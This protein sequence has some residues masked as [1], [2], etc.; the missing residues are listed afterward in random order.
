MTN[1]SL[2]P[3]SFRKD[4]RADLAG[5]KPV[6]PTAYWRPALPLAVVLGLAACTVPNVSPG[7]DAAKTLLSTTDTD[8]RPKLAPVA[9][10]ELARAEQDYVAQGKAIVELLGTCRYEDARTNGM[11]LPDCH[12]VQS[13]LPDHGPVNATEVLEA[14]DVLSNYFTALAAIAS[15]DSSDAVATQT[16]AVID[17]LSKLGSGSGSSG[18]AKIAAF[19]A[20]NKDQAVTSV[21]F[22]AAQY[23]VAALRRVVR[24]A[25]P[26]IDALVQGA[27]LYLDARP[28]GL[29]AAEQNMT[30][31]E[32]AMTTA[33]VAHDAAGQTR[34]AQDLRTTFAAFHQAAATDPANRL[35]LLRKLH[36]DLLHGLTG[37]QSAEDYLTTLEQIRKIADLAQ[38][39]V[40]K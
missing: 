34:A 9:A 37:P 12:L 17:A 29:V 28:G 18:L 11:I 8:L 13:A 33:A 27:V 5:A 15:A 39:G 16:G 31:A 10:Q 35:L 36:G 3:R 22:L 38:Q 6:L 30:R 19:A 32:R 23:R 2:L 24:K 25:D 14:L 20:A 40:G 4:A 7:I 26:V 1:R 21:G